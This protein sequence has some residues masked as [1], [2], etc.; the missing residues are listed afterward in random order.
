MKVEILKNIAG[1][2]FSYSE[3]QI[4]DIKK[5]LAEDLIR[6]NYAKPIEKKKKK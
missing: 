2:D 3:G 4:V 1:I 6:A 5:E